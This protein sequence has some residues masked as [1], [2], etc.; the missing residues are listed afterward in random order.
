MEE[1]EILLTGKEYHKTM[2]RFIMAEDGAD[3]ERVDFNELGNDAKN[4]FHGT[5]VMKNLIMIDALYRRV[6]SLEARITVLEG[7]GKTV[8]STPIPEFKTVEPTPEPQPEIESETKI[9]EPPVLKTV[10]M[11]KKKSGRPKKNKKNS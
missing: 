11:P 10:E 6:K 7:K 9:E 5:P 4:Q 8:D 2:K 1:A 3:L